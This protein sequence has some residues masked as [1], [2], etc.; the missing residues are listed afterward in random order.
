M[1]YAAMQFVD[2]GLRCTQCTGVERPLNQSMDVAATDAN[3]A[4]SADKCQ[5]TRQCLIG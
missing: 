1:F 4:K 2:R 3:S 5:T